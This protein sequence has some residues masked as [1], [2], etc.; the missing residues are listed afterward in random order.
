MMRPMMPERN[1]TITRELMMANQWILSSVICRYTS[2]R[3]PH[4]TSERSHTTSY[5][6]TTSVD[7]LGL[8]FIGS[9]GS[10][11]PVGGCVHV[12]S[13]TCGIASSF[14]TVYLCSMENGTT[15]GL[16]TNCFQRKR[17]Q[18]AAG[19]LARLSLREQ[20]QVRAQARPPST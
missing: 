16:K 17:L 19:A 14:H 6:H 9:C 13:F 4:F 12:A 7:S 5:V 10:N 11:A 3:V 20:P 8:I 18:R 15:W 2:Q 1:M